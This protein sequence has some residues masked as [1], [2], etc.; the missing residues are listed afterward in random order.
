MPSLLCSVASLRPRSVAAL[1]ASAVLLALA[2]AGIL[3]TPALAHT[4]VEVGPYSLVFGWLLEPVVVGERNA[5]LIVITEGETPVEGLES[6]LDAEIRYAGRE[7]S[8]NLAPGDEPGDYVV[9][10]VPTVR[11]QYVVHL[12]GTIGEETVDLTV[13]PEEVLG[14]EVMQFPEPVPD[15]RELKL[16]MDA[17]EARLRTAN[18]LAI[19]G[20]SLGA[21]GILLAAFTYLRSRR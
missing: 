4:R 13:E 1:A 9:E 15:G 11:G 19:I 8:G 2:L 3:I 18:T 10:F 12:T 5:V 17:L 6:T 21:V 20:V 14:P 7:L 16:S